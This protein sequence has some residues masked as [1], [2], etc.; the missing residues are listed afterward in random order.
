[1]KETVTPL[2]TMRETINSKNL[3]AKIVERARLFY[4][5]L[6]HPKSEIKRDVEW[7]KRLKV[8]EIN[9]IETS[10]L[11]TT[12]NETRKESTTCCILQDSW[13]TLWTLYV[14]PDPDTLD[15]SQQI[16]KNIYKSHKWK[17]ISHLNMLLTTQL[18]SLKRKGYPV[19]RI[20][21]QPKQQRV[22]EKYDQKMIDQENEENLSNDKMNN[23]NVS[24]GLPPKI[25]SYVPKL[26]EMFPDCDP[27]HI[28]QLLAKQKNDHLNNVANTLA[29]GDYPKIKPKSQQTQKTQQNNVS[30]DPVNDDSNKNFGFFDKVKRVKDLIPTLTNVSAG[31]STSS[32]PMES[33]ANKEPVHVTPETTRNLR[34]SLKEG[35]RTCRSNSGSAIDNQASVKVVDESQTSYCDVIPGMSNRLLFFFF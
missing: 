32:K 35:I 15:I 9:Q 30:T 17:D 29:E 6:D 4:Y 23:N 22:V 13:S 21:R 14:T 16:V 33:S 24:S 27:N 5:D 1:V 7:L 25:E 19:D 20:L 3:Q 10:Y 18:T 26:Q 34:S 11:L 31:T 2:G 12:T 28:R 8:R